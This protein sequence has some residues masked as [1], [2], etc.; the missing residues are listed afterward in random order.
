MTMTSEEVTAANVANLSSTHAHTRSGDLEE[1][2]VKKGSVSKDEFHS[3]EI[4]SDA[5][6][7]RKKYPP[8]NTKNRILISLLG[9]VAVGLAISLI[10]K[11]MTKPE[12][13]HPEDEHSR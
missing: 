1:F 11:M 2:W 12:C 6:L 5:M 8:R 7:S 4:Q 13:Y 10:K 3:E 9:S